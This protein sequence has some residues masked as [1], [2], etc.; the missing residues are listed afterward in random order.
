MFTYRTKPVFFLAA[1]AAA[2]LAPAM[3]IDTAQA[4]DVPT[5]QVRICIPPRLV[6]QEFWET[7]YP[8]GDMWAFK[9][10]L[11]H[12]VATHGGSGQ[13]AYWIADDAFARFRAAGADSNTLDARALVQEMSAQSECPASNYT[14]EQ[15]VDAEIPIPT[16]QASTY[17][18]PAEAV[19]DASIDTSDDI[20][21]Y[22]AGA[23]AAAIVWCILGGCSS[24]EPSSDDTSST[25]DYGQPADPYNN[26]YQQYLDERH[27]ACV[28]AYSDISNC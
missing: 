7:P 26:A 5:V 9:N 3:S 11:V 2:Y 14:A 24:D 19:G 8:G 20:T 13:I 6:T 25:Y 18:E 22:V 15:Q 17:S 10:A 16:T 1:I 4:A 21:G 27:A 23:A 12:Y 28:W